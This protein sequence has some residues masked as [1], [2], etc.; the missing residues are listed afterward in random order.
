MDA[1][2]IEA[3]TSMPQQQRIRLTKE[4]IGELEA[5]RNDAVPLGTV[6]DTLE[7]EG[8]DRDRAKKDIEGLKARGEVYEPSSG[9]VRTS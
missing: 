5:E 9:C 3:G 1:D 8:I 7:E 2:V 4:V 6:L